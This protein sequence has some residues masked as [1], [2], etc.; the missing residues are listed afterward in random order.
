M[1]KIDLYNLYL[2]ME[3][4]DVIL[5]F[6]GDVS[7]DLLSSVYQIVEARLDSE[8]EDPKRKKKLFYVLVE[9]LQNLYNHTET[10]PLKT[11]GFPAELSG[12]AIFLIGKTNSG[13]YRIVTGNNIRSENAGTLKE[14]IDKINSMTPP[15]LKSYYLETLNST[16]LS[17]KGG[18]GLGMIEIAR[19]SGNNLEYDFYTTSDNYTFFTL[20]VEIS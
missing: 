20:S 16:E 2:T 17:E 7:K 10:S 9:C 6:K 4:E 5:A 18:A 15:Q 11:D 12:S 19:K 14:R 1:A 8:N 13:G 3:R